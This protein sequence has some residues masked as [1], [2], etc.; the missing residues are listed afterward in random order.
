MYI[1]R[2][3]KIDFTQTLVDITMAEIKKGELGQP[4]VFC[5]VDNRMGIVSY[6]NY[7]DHHI[8]RLDNLSIQIR[9]LVRKLKN[10]TIGFIFEGTVTSNGGCS[11][12]M[13][14]SIE[15]GMTCKSIIFALDGNRNIIDVDECISTVSDCPVIRFQNF[16]KTDHIFNNYNIEKIIHKDITITDYKTDIFSII[17]NVTSVSEPNLEFSF[18]L[19]KKKKSDR[20]FSSMLNYKTSTKDIDEYFLNKKYELVSWIKNYYKVDNNKTKIQGEAI[21]VYNLHIKTGIMLYDIYKINDDRSLTVIENNLL[22]PN[23]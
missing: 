7:G 20:L 9:S 18:V 5:Y 3:K 2:E 21:F 22:L 13:I 1:M 4:L 8:D 11:D 6:N 15:D 19:Y 12:A 14:L 17:D 23:E 10:C 16:Y